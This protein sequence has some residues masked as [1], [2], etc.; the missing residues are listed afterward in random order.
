[1]KRNGTGRLLAGLLALVMVLVLL[2]VGAAKADEGSLKVGGTAI[3][4]SQNGSYCDGK[5]VFEIIDGKNVLTLNDYQLENYNR[6]GISA[7]EIDL[8][9]VGSAEIGVTGAAASAIFVHEG[10][11]TLNGDFTLRAQNVTGATLDVD[12][13][14]TV[15]GGAL[16][17]ENTG[18]GRNAIYVD[19][20]MTVNGGTVHA[21]ANGAK[22]IYA[23]I[24]LNN[25]ETYLLGDASASEV[26]IGVAEYPLWV[27]GVQVTSANQ[28]DIFGDGTAKFEIIDGKNVLTLN[29]YKL[30][31]YNFSGILADG[32]DLT[33]VGSA[34]I[35]VTGATA[36][37]IAVNG[38]L[39]LNG[40]FTLRADRQTGAALVVVGNLTVEGG[41]LDVENT[42][43]GNGA[44]SIPGTMTVNGGTVH[45]KA[46]GTNAI[47]ARIILNNGE[48][49]LLGDAYASEV[50][51]GKVY[52]LYVGY[53]RVNDLNKGDIFGDG[54]AKFEITEEGENVLTLNDFKLENY[55]GVGISADGIDLTI[56]GSASIGVTGAV[57]SAIIVNEGNLT[58]NGDFTLRAQCENGVALF[59]FGYLTVEGGA[60]DVENTGEGSEAI[61]AHGAMTVNSGTV[62]AKANGTNA[63]TAYSITLNNGETYL[64]GD[65]YASE[66][67]IGVPVE[68]TITF[69]NEDGT[70]LQS[71]EVLLGKTPAYTGKEPTKPATAQYTYTFVGW[72]DENGIVYGLTDDL[73]AVTGEMTYTAIYTSTVNEYTIT[74]VNE[75]GTELQSGKVAYGETPEYKG[76]TPTKAHTD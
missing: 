8:T 64:L 41:A 37:V 53:K 25:G 58:L 67:K 35:G 34:E 62:H 19:D 49:Y 52:P 76:E 15:E 57:S 21:K 71:G 72:K 2:P 60:L 75:D 48:Q 7:R 20:R 46:N 55:I 18:E 43:E 5:V 70:E 36:S 10:N 50:F 45:A 74:F 63:I 33:I 26:K 68:Y 17:V 54:T 59:L 30:E 4:L 9:I 27:G 22:V 65:A 28:D 31:N 24:I 44:I 47:Y 51:I 66:V 23:R 29:G 73:P 69:V 12:G 38:N 14:L 1:M 6:S 39:T 56:V 42:Y 11:L 32:L 13:N 61:Y 16:D 3:D 40:D